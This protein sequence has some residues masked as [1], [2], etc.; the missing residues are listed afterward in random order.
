MV[1][2]T[3]YRLTYIIL[4]QRI[5]YLSIILG[6]AILGAIITS[7]YLI[8]ENTLKMIIVEIIFLAGF[9][10]RMIMSFSP[11]IYASGTRTFIYFYFAMIVCGAL[12]YNNISENIEEE[13]QKNILFYIGIVAAVNYLQLLINI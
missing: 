6:F 1:L 8:F 9:F 11:T 12:I 7:I 13:K 4:I 10:S 5:N 3:L 2:M